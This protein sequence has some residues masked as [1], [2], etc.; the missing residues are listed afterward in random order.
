MS[1]TAVVDQNQLFT[2]NKGVRLGNN[3]STDSEANY[4]IIRYNTDTNK[5]EGLHKLAGADI[6]GNVWRQF[7]LE[8]ASTSVLGGFKV[9]TNLNMN[10][11]T[12]VLASVAAGESRIYQHV[13][14]IS[15]IIGAGDY[16]TIHEAIAHAIGI[17]P[18]NNGAITSNSGAPSY[19]NQYLLLL[20]PGQYTENNILPDFV[21]IY[22]D[23]NGC[24]F[25][26][27]DTANAGITTNGAI[28]ECGDTSSIHD[29][30]FMINCNNS[31]VDVAAISS[32]NKSNI[33][34]NAINV[35]DSANCVVNTLS[36]I[37]LFG[38]GSNN[39]IENS[40]V[41]ITNSLNAN[42]TA[43][44][45][46]N[47]D[48][49]INKNT[50]TIS[51]NGLINK[52]I[53]LTG[54]ANVL[55]ENTNIYCTGGTDNYGIHNIRTNLEVVYSSIKCESSDFQTV[56]NV[57]CIY[58]LASSPQANLISTNIEFVRN[59][60]QL[61]VIHAVGGVDDFIALG[62]KPDTYIQIT[63]SSIPT[64]NTYFHIA[65]VN[66]DALT[67]YPSADLTYES[68]GN[69]ITLKCLYSIR[70]DYSTLLAS[71]NSSSISNTVL[72]GDT[73]GNY[74]IDVS[75]SQ[76]LGGVINPNNSLVILK[77]LN[78][79]TVANKGGDYYLISEALNAI[80]DSSVNNR[81]LIN[82][83]SGTYNEPSNIVC[84]PYINIVGSGIGDVIVNLN[85]DSP[86]PDITAASVIL[87]SNTSLF[88]LVF[89]NVGQISGNYVIGAWG[90][91]LT[92]II[93]RD[94][95]ISAS[96]AGI[97]TGIYCS[98][99][100]LSTYHN[101]FLVS[102]NAGE[103]TNQ[104]LY[105]YICNLESQLDTIT[106]SGLSVT[107]N[108]G[109]I[110]GGCQN[111]KF[112]SPNISVTD[113]SGV[114]DGI[115]C[116]NGVSP[117]CNI[118]IHNGSIIASG[119][120][121]SR[122]IKINDAYNIVVVSDSNI[123]GRLEYNEALTS[124]RIR[125][126]NC[127]RLEG[128]PEQFILLNE[129]GENSNPQNNLILGDTAGKQGI[130]GEGDTIIGSNAGISMTTGSHN[131]LIGGFAGN[132][133]DTGDN[134]TAIGFQA[135][136]SLVSG[137]NNTVVGNGSGSNLISGIRNILM[138]VNA[139][140]YTSNSNDNVVIGDKA[141]LDI[142]TGNNNILIGTNACES[143]DTVNDNIMI[144]SNTGLSFIQGNNNLYI[145]SEAG[146]SSVI[147]NN[148][149]AIGYNAGHSN[150][151]SEN[152]F[153]GSNAGFSNNYGIQNTYIGTYS[154]VAASTGNNNT[155]I[156]FQSGYNNNTG[157]ANTLL[158]A[159]SGSGITTGSHNTLIGTSSSYN[160]NTEPGYSNTSGDDV[161]IIGVDS[162]YSMTSNDNMIVGNYSGS[163]LTT[164][165]RNVMLGNYTGNTGVTVTD[166]VLAGYSAGQLS[167]G[168]DNVIMG[169]FAGS[170]AVT[171]VGS[172]IIG[173]QAGMKQNGVNNVFIGLQAGMNSQSGS[174]LAN[175]NVAIGAFVGR[176]I[177]GGNRNVILGGGTGDLDATGSSIENGS[178]NI[179]VG[180]RAGKLIVNGSKNMIMGS[181][182][183]KSLT[184]GEGNL[185]L[186]YQSG[187][188]IS[189][190]LYNIML[191]YQAGYSQTISNT[192]IF[193]GY[194]AGYANTVGQNNI[195]IGNQAGYSSVISNNNA[196]V[197]YQ[198]GFNTQGDGNLNY[199]HQAGYSNT[200]GNNNIFMGYQVAFTGSGGFDHTADFN[201]F[202]GNKA[203][204]QTTSGGRNIF[205]GNQS[206][207]TNSTGAKN[208]FF[209]NNA[210]Y[211]NI[212]G[213]KN[214]FIGAT[215]SDNSGVG[216]ENTTGFNNTFIGHQ[217]GVANTTG[218]NN[219]F[220]GSQAGEQNTAGIRN[221]YMGYLAGNY[222]TSGNDN[223]NIGNQAG[224]HNQTGI[225]NIFIGYQAGGD[226]SLGSSNNNVIAIGTLAGTKAA[227]DDLIFIGHA[228]GL[229]NSTGIHNIAIGTSAGEFLETGN[230]NTMIGTNAGKSMVTTSNNTII[231]SNAGAN[232][233]NANNIF[234][235]ADAG[236]GSTDARQNVV[237]GSQV[238]STGNAN[239]SVLI[240][241]R[242]G[243]VNTADGVICIGSQSGYSNTAGN[244]IFIGYVSGFN[245][246]SGGAN[247]MIGRESGFFNQSGANN[248][249]LGVYAGSLNNGNQ[250]I[251]LGAAALQVGTLA[252]NNIC[253]GVESGRDTNSDD[254]IFIGS[255]AGN[256]NVD[257]THNIG[258]GTFAMGN[259]AAS[260]SN[261]NTCIGYYAGYNTTTPNNIF[262]GIQSGLMNLSGANCLF[263]GSNTGINNNG[264]NN[265]FV[266]TEAGYNN[267]TG[268][269]NIC[270]GFNAGYSSMYASNNIYL[271]SLAGA[272]ASA[273]TSICI[274]YQ[275]GQ[276]ITANNNILIGL[277]AG[278]NITSEN[279][280]CFGINAGLNTN[281]ANNIFMGNYTGTYNNNGSG[282]IFMGLQSGLYNQN[283]IEN[284][285]LG[286]LTGIYNSDGSY[287][288]FLGN[289]AG[290]NNYTG[291]VNIYIG[292][293]AGFYNTTGS[294]NIFIG[295]NAGS[296]SND[297]HKNTVIG[298]VAGVYLGNNYYNVMIGYGT[299]YWVGADLY[300]PHDFN[301]YLG[302]FCGQNVVGKNNILIGNEEIDMIDDGNFIQGYDN[303]FAI[304]HST[305]SLSDNSTANCT[306]LIGGK[307]RGT[308]AG[309]VGIGTVVPETYTH[310]TNPSILLVV[311]GG[312][313]AT[314]YSTF[315]GQHD[316][317]LVSNDL[318]TQ[319]KPGLI[320][321]S[322]GNTQLID[323]NNTV[324]TL[325]LSAIYNDKRVFGIYSYSKTRT[326]ETP[327]SVTNPFVPP[328]PPI[329]SY[330]T[331][332][333]VNA[334]GEGAI[335]ISNYSGEIQNG[336]YITSSP[337]PGYGTLQSD[338]LMHSYTVAKCTE[339]IDWSNVTETIEYNGI[340][341]KIIFVTCTYH[342]G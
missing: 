107:Y 16:Q 318:I 92:N 189:G 85:V 193:I 270:F 66:I 90:V 104:G 309:M 288:I 179:L 145:G 134:N 59:L 217:V 215:D 204:Y 50:I 80:V 160:G 167:E 41:Y 219:L 150:S 98:N 187:S 159:K 27:M 242:A 114:N 123:I 266:G 148:V 342:C 259:T 88:N 153:I 56:S 126:L 300:N 244:N 15:P 62:F 109:V 141:G 42:R 43:I 276:N 71:S 132:G 169:S 54:I 130:L 173:K 146:Y 184:N 40:N 162:G 175:D 277:N 225:Q 33:H 261:N 235:G 275:A 70:A 121:N 337:I 61:D 8:V 44:N 199:G 307:T 23:N 74:S 13:I 287:N 65:G 238:M 220:M 106:V 211:K 265:I 39:S 51:N 237:I 268:V 279:N 281:G 190:A 108:I 86:T 2:F 69:S 176:R 147:S 321:S 52:G 284:T 133:L 105:M 226:F 294:D 293:A 251:A 339:N 185:V 28:I 48:V 55:I 60:G 120:V 103:D 78:K 308:N 325:E 227:S 72:I 320:M 57:A 151:M 290:S 327:Q 9:G 119:S 24:S 229:N 316:F 232:V 317:N 97:L 84:K 191:G 11:Y 14:T 94:C 192:T 223:I 21:S 264:D 35:Y 253:I 144:G 73:Y 292:R 335:W 171:T 155:T 323:I 1:G 75:T 64:N 303:T 282:N 280:I 77:S 291:N 163:V 26:N 79:I 101:K 271:G 263:I 128:S 113:S 6:F 99:C 138:G 112:D 240:G 29:I 213:A 38:G 233:N 274:G 32:N 195:A 278:Q 246:I 87:A 208:I 203:G 164:G 17:S 30:T 250:N 262:I 210:G 312:V 313:L 143:A 328:P 67:L 5:F 117:T 110:A 311:N 231:G 68:A 249:Y 172:V 302:N 156:G 102:G 315:T 188:N 230:N 201:T 285:C 340:S 58:G 47:T 20:A 258:I 18:Y 298:N 269:N 91:N 53:N 63:G 95:T 45:V 158:G 267:I 186:G 218:A 286:T 283:G 183:G 180:Y 305:A 168:N 4:G 181:E 228:A 197:G 154:S 177:D 12:G 245:T 304:Y 222:G 296:Q 334:L 333:Y 165:S 140:S 224:Y 239:N 36:G 329:I 142:S 256:I 206:G 122:A 49:K 131:T 7:E 100:T 96:G 299:G 161:I 236:Y 25:L 118:E 152:V 93:I 207:Y 82:V 22:G 338:D 247:I 139:L 46:T 209:G 200:T 260:T 182:A 301:I 111:V 341:Y 254:N 127:Y 241:F 196:F 10:P 326:I 198:A 174:G 194:Q 297:S 136:N 89:N 125:C 19:Y 273:S 170:N 76:L 166:S 257:G 330:I 314:S 135:L 124:S 319:L 310:P 331:S 255:K 272:N 322:T 221:I 115:S 289:F 336:D 202:I 137:S 129:R 248:I 81:Y 214:I 34:I 252:N 31:S 295:L 243:S 234:I 306:V 83:E 332:Y 212:D 178:D 37:S 157:V 149:I 216:Y 3:D 324:N 116:T 205:V